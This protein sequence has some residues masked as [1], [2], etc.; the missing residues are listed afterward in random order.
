MTNGEEKNRWE[1]SKSR[2]AILRQERTPRFTKGTDKRIV[3]LYSSFGFDVL[4]IANVSVFANLQ[5]LSSITSRHY[6]HLKVL[7][8]MRQRDIKSG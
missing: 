4:G 2:L 7:C 5:P 6:P 1:Q 8:Y 3:S